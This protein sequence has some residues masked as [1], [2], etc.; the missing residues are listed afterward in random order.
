MKKQA[1]KI[2]AFRLCEETKQQLEQMA[3]EVMSEAETI[4]FCVNKI[5]N[6]DYRATDKTLPEIIIKKYSLD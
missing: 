6:T 4:E 5:Y 3:D 2:Y 1:K